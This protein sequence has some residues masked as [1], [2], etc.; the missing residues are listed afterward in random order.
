[1]TIRVGSA[2]ALRRMGI[3]LLAATVAATGCGNKAP[4]GRSVSALAGSPFESSDGNLLLEPT[5]GTVGQDWVNAP[6]RVEK[7]DAPSGATDNSFGQGAKEDKPNPSVVAGSIP[8]NKSDL[9]RFYVAHELVG[10]DFFLYL[11]WERSNVLG[12]ANMDFEFNQSSTLDTN[13]VTPERTAGDILITFDFVNGGSKPVLGLLRWVTTGS[14]EQCLANNALPCWGNRVDLSAAG[15][16]DGAVNTADVVDPIAPDAPRTLPAYTFGEAAINLS[17]ADVFPAGQCVNYANAFLKSRSSASFT[18]ELKDFIAPVNANISNCGTIR[19]EKRIGSTTGNP[20]SGATF[21]LFTGS[22]SGDGGVGTTCT[23]SAVTPT[24][25]CSTGSDGK[26]SMTDVPFGTYC[27]AE[28]VTPSGYF[29]ATAQTATVSATSAS[30]TLTFV[31]LPQPG[32]IKITKYGYDKGVD[33]GQRPLSGA[34]FSIKDASGTVVGTGTSDASGVVCVD[35]LQPLG[36]TFTVTETAAPTGWAIDTTS[37]TVTLS[38]NADCT[39]SSA[40]A[41]NAVT[42]TDTPLSTI[43]VS[44]ASEVAPG[45]TTATIQCTGETTAADLPEGTPKT[46]LHLKPGTYSCTVVIDP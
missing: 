15:W 10:G 14:A 35:N 28:T 43:T 6:N 8:P 38:G 25:S 39:A 3:G 7:L 19:I 31:D 9:T 23:G 13:T 29:T 16:A 46:L 33:G 26:C 11:A 32:A 36:A 44:F 37:Q 45:V 21:Q 17:D 12:S 2:G 24:F 18:A 34:T 41:P 27:V 5:D 20:L 4:T 40:N 1:M 22:P 30:V 42:F